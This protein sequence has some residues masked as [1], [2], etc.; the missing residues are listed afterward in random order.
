MTG[1]IAA[2]EASIARGELVRAFDLIQQAVAE[3]RGCERLQYLKALA[4]ARMNDPLGALAELGSATSSEDEDTLALRGRVFK[5]LATKAGGKERTRL[6]AAAADAYYDAHERAGG[7]F[8][9]INAATAAFLAGDKEVAARRARALLDLVEVAQPATFYAAASAGEA[10]LLLANARAAQSAFQHALTLPGADAGARASAVRQLM[11]LDESLNRG[12]AARL[13]MLLRPPTVVFYSGH[14]FREDREVEAQLARHITNA[15][16][17][18]S[19]AVAYG[20]AAAGA[21]ILFCEALLARGAELNLVLPMPVDDFVTHSVMPF[22]KGWRGRFEQVCAAAHSLSL[23]S[24]VPYIGDPLQFAYGNSIAMGLA[25]LRADHLCTDAAMLVVLDQAEQGLAGGAADARKIWT[26]AG[27]RVVTLSAGS[28]DRTRD[29]VATPACA[30]DREI[31]AVVFTDYAGF[32]KLGEEA[33]AL[34]VERVLGALGEA[35]AAAG[36]AVLQRNT[37]GDALFAVLDGAAS[38]AELALDIQDRVAR[39][40]PQSLGLDPAAG[41]RVAIHAGPLYRAL[42]PVTGQL[43]FFGSEVTRTAR[44]EPVAPVGQVYGTQAFAALLA[45]EGSGRFSAHYVGSIPLA[46]GYGAVPMHRIMRAQGPRA[47]ELR[48]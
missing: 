38:A 8:S 37:W 5:D 1:A 4:L 40:D 10:H 30:F 26:D 20:A 18:E 48:Q 9:L 21:D 36:T 22:G 7:Y 23:T 24:D 44:I 33:V 34:F 12:E 17:A 29:A 31:R 15:L 6:Y 13:A 16:E 19:C 42:D 39:V 35:L 28:V 32:S 43:G 25:S 46:K 3:G 2:V 45:L 47:A 14:M 27:R 41:M 11:L